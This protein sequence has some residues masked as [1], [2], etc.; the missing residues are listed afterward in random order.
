MYHFFHITYQFCHKNIAIGRIY[1]IKAAD[2]FEFFLIFPFFIIWY[3][4][5]L[6]DIGKSDVGKMII[7]SQMDKA[8]KKKCL[9]PISRPSQKNFADS[10]KFFSIFQEK[11][12][13]SVNFGKKP[14]REDAR[15]QDGVR[16]SRSAPLRTC[17]VWYHDLFLDKSSI[18]L[19]KERNL[20]IL[21]KRDR[22]LPRVSAKK[23]P[24]LTVRVVWKVNKSL[25]RST[26]PQKDHAEIKFQNKIKFRSGLPTQI[27]LGMVSETEAFFFWPKLLQL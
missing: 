20:H 21:F 15:I 13:I 24:L 4:F 1:L 18:N 14:F 5:Y 16:R 9:F 25:Q 7:S 8:K 3:W 2:V 17:F 22:F 11:K 10:T 6:Q 26:Q 12:F 19:D 23:G 27:F